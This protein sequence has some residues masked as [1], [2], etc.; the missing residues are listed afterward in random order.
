MA[1]TG[2]FVDVV[3]QIPIAFERGGVDAGFHLEL[4]EVIDFGFVEI[5]QV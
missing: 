3:F 2:V 4:P 5:L 1:E